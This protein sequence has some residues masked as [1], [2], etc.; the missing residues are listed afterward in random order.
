M[1]TQK[2]KKMCMGSALLVLVFCSD[3]FAQFKVPKGQDC[4]NVFSKKASAIALKEEVYVSPKPIGFMSKDQQYGMVLR[5]LYTNG[6][7]HAVFQ[8][9]SN[10]SLC[11]RA[12]AAIGIKFEGDGDIYAEKGQNK[13]NCLPG[14]YVDK[15]KMG[16]SIHVIPI[17]SLMFKYLMTKSVEAVGVDTN[18]SAVVVQPLD[19]ET[20]KEVKNLFRCVYEALGT[21]V[22]FSKDSLLINNGHT[23]DR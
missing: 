1:T 11:I 19:E 3:V 2:I 6:N 12:N 14:R 17:N 18:K 5:M 21:D 16:M 7:L 10:G 13:E 4:E 9:A 20:V 8:I 22:D 15:E 23:P